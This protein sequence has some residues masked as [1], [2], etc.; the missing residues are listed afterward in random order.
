MDK[1]IFWKNT[2]KFKDETDKEKLLNKLR[3][4]QGNDDIENAHYD[5]DSAL[6]D[7]IDDKDINKEY[8]KIAK[9]Y[10]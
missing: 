1:P 3:K 4:L 10:A 6:L 9:W 2:K 8:L 5:A 7:F